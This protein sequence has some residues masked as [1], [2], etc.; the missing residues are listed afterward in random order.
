MRTILIQFL[1]SAA[2]MMSAVFIPVFAAQIGASLAEIGMIGASYGVAIFFSSYIFGRASDMRD[3]R[4]FLTTGLLLSCVTFFLQ[5]LA[6]SPLPLMVIRG[7]AGFSLG[8]FT[9]P[10]I[11]YTFESGVKL[12][13]FSSYGSLGWAFGAILAGIIAQYSE[14]YAHINALIPFWS[15]FI[16]S[17]MLFAISYIVSAKLPKVKMKT[18]KVSLFPAELIKRNMRVYL[19]A[20]LRHLGAFSI[21]IIFPLFLADLGAGKFW[22]GFMY[23]VNAGA[24]FL[25]MRRLD[26]MKD[27]LLINL[28]LLLS[29]MVFF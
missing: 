28:G 16:I 5:A 26:I 17:S 8:I 27:T 1:S 24:Q 2:V 9:A 25:I 10:L 18:V 23:F 22:I 15:V 14:S 13:M 3:R 4:I 6:W 21:W 11:A 12:G 19:P 20:F 7:L 29:V